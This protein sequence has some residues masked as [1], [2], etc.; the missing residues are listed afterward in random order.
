MKA[1]SMKRREFLAA[2]GAAATVSILPRHVLA[3]S[4]QT[5]P[6]EKLN[7]AGIG[8]GSQGRAT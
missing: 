3:A 2:A 4:A 8:L 7:L 6:S 5:P 1:N